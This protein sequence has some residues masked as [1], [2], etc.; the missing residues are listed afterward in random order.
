MND[1]PIDIGEELGFYHRK[2]SKHRTLPKIQR[3]SFSE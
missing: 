3:Y 2:A 1:I